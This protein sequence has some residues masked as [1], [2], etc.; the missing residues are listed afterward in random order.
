M[1][2]LLALGLV[3]MGGLLVAG[4]SLPK[5]LGLG[6]LVLALI[7]WLPRTWWLGGAGVLCLLALPQLFSGAFWV[8]R[9]ALGRR[10]A[11]LQRV[12]DSRRRRLEPLL[13]PAADKAPKDVPSK[14]GGG[15]S[16]ASQWVRS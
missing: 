6:I 8:V 16:N 1:G 5:R 15:S 7:P 2:G 13:P 10:Q 9:W 3:A 12:A 4:M 14:P 11:G